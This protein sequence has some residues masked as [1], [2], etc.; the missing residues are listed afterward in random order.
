[1]AR[2]IGFMANRTDLL[3]DVLAQ[4]ASVTHPPAGADAWGMGFY[5]GGEVLHKK[6]PLRDGERPDWGELVR[7][8]RTD[9]ALL[10]VRKATVGGFRV[11]NTHPFRMRRWLFAHNGTI[12]GFERLQRRFLEA[13][14]DFIRRN[15]RG[16]TD[17]E[18]FFHVLLAMLHDVGQLDVLE[19]D[20]EAVLSALRATVSTVDRWVE[21]IG[22]Q[23]ASLD[24][25]LTN[26]QLLLALRRGAQR[27]WTEV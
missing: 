8:V 18:H 4:E 5:Q 16:E 6:R 21:E 15:V 26:G 20:V 24:A 19:P 23:P 10:H 1:M 3:A 2:L 13:M 14:P 27:G 11:D 9:C 17:S 22:E 25:M 7:G 12:P